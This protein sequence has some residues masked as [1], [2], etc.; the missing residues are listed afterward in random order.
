KAMS[1]APEAPSSAA[2]AQDGGSRLD[3]LSKHLDVDIANGIKELDRSSL[4]LESVAQFCRTNYLNA[5]DRKEREAAVRQTEKY[6]TQSL[7]SVAYQINVLA[8]DFQDLL[9]LETG[10]LSRLSTDIGSLSARVS[11]HKERMARRHI[12]QLTTPRPAEPLPVA[13]QHRMPGIVYH[14]GANAP[15]PAPP[16]YS[17]QPIDYSVLDSIGH[18]VVEQQSGVVN[19][20]GSMTV[21]RQAGRQVSAASTGRGAVDRGASG[22][23]STIAGGASGSRRGSA[24]TAS[25]AGSHPESTG[26][27]RRLS[28]VST[29]SSKMIT[30]TPAVAEP[31]PPPPAP[32]PAPPLPTS[33]MPPRTQTPLPPPPP[34]EPELPEPQ[35]DSSSNAN[36]DISSLVPQ[37]DEQLVPHQPSDPGW[38]PEFYLR[39]VVAIYDYISDVSDELT[40]SEGAVIYVVRKNDD[41]WWEGYMEPGVSGLFPGNYV[42]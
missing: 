30:A 7:A 16:R 38:A 12:G 22:N 19:P 11:V 21:G 31:P 34:P 26:S 35:F 13:G 27:P 5:K 25:V 39:R 14:A 8:K 32:P 9:D 6:A 37:A 17:R 42:E 28:T 36:V 1:A 10:E 24:V 40:F 33:A 2:V 20:D 15:P 29:A 41:G 23:Y 4:S 18:G 3:E